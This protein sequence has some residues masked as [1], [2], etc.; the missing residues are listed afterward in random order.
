MEPAINGCLAHWFPELATGCRRRRAAGTS[1]AE[2]RRLGPVGLDMARHASSPRHNRPKRRGAGKACARRPGPAARAREAHPQVGSLK[3]YH[4]KRDVSITAEPRGRKSARGGFRYLIQKHDARR[5]HYDFRLQLGGVLKSWAVTRGP[6]LDP[7]DRRLAVHVEDHPLGYGD[8]EGTIP[9]PQYGGGTV[10]LWD[11]GTWEP[12]DD[13]ERMYKSGRLKFRIKGKKLHGEWHLVRMGRSRHA[14]AD[15]RA[16]NWLLIKSRDEFARPGDGDRIL[17]EGLSVKTGRTMTTIALE[18]GAPSD[19]HHDAPQRPKAERAAPTRQT[20]ATK[21][22]KP[23]PM[24]GF[25]APQLATRVDHPPE[26]QGWV[27]EL[28]YDGYRIEARLEGGA[29]RLLTRNGLDWTARFPTLAAAI[30]ELRVKS[31]LIDGEIVA[32]DQRNHSD[33]ALLQQLF[34]ER[35]DDG[36]AYI[37]FDLLFL[38]GR[39]LRSLPLIERK[40]LLARLVPKGSSRLRYSD[41]IAGG[42][43][44]IYRHA[45]G[46]ALEGIVSKRGADPYVSGRGPGWLKSKCRERQEFVIGGYTPRSDDD[47]SIGSLLLGY[48]QDEKFIY[49]GRIGTGLSHGEARNLRRQLD[50]LGRPAANFAALPTAVGRN[51]TLVEPRL[52]CE[53]EFATWTRGGLIR[54]GSFIALRADKDPSTVGRERVEPVKTVGHTDGSDNRLVEIAGIRLTHPDRVLYEEQGI[55][56]RQLAEYYASIAER[57]L[58]HVADRPLSIVRCP[59][60]MRQECFYQKHVSRGM[61][62]AVKPVRVK[63]SSG[64]AEYV[65]ISDVAGL[66]ALVQFGVL[67]IHPWSARSVDIESTDR[68]IFDLDPGPGVTWARL[69][70]AALE[71]KHRLE[72]VKL[73]SFVKTTGGKGLHVVVPLRPS[74]GWDLAKQFSH[75]VALAMATSAPA[76]YVAKS[77]KSARGNRIFVDYLRNQRGAKAVAPYSTRARPAAPVSMPLEWSELSVKLKPERFGI[78]NAGQ[79]PAD[80]WAGFFEQRQ[81]IDRGTLKRLAASA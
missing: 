2:P 48:W 65:S 63:D 51:A 7:A 43:A 50:R 69:I 34:S 24:P 62:A 25:V 73:A 6:S 75:A 57:I 18:D 35:R 81:T 28:K 27:H 80:A 53:I 79:R 11:T 61:P 3:R 74:V 10:M 70:E 33:F 60:G 23:M 66:A 12:L 20:A 71:V 76:H 37:A 67:E 9:K 41:H 44:K 15:S 4:A 78:E 64:W 5:P 46:L 1:P 47:Q 45:C 56:K 49:A 14:A 26:D 36:L 17:D 58:P 38:D 59:S 16:D 21:T 54:Q 32:L 29:V 72:A 13:P 22:G 31:A 42:G 8:F 39:D 55:T 52:V 68:L 19:A 77:T 30:G 40:K